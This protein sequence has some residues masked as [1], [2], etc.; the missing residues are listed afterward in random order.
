MSTR[1]RNKKKYFWGVQRGRCVRLPS[2][3]VNR[4]CTVWILNISQSYRTPR[5]VTEIALLY[6]Q[7]IGLRRKH[8]HEPSRPVTGIS[9]LFICRWYSSSQ[10]T[11]LWAPT[12]GYWD[13][14]T[15]YMQMMFI[16]HRKHTHGPPRPVTGRTLL[17]LLHF[18]VV[19]PLMQR[20]LICLEQNFEAV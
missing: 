11:H 5:A 2:P 15:V 4:W 1:D 7:M 3:S 8:I 12:A 18:L 19:S 20:T 6:M 10:E 17:Y 9:L 13:S 14:F 16:P